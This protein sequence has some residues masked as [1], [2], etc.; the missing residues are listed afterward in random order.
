[1]S[2]RVK[3][4]PRASQVEMASRALE[5]YREIEHRR[6]QIEQQATREQLEQAARRQGWTITE[7]KEPR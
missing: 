3:A 5:E 6:A 7:T 4:R 1:L 2:K